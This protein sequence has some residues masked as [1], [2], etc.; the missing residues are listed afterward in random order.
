MWVRPY[1]LR[2]EE[3]GAYKNLMSELS[4]ENPEVNGT[5]W[6]WT[7]WSVTWPFHIG[8]MR[9]VSHISNVP[10]AGQ[11][12]AH[13]LRCTSGNLVVFALRFAYLHFALR[14]YNEDII[15]TIAFFLRLL[16]LS[17]R[18]LNMIN[19]FPTDGDRYRVKRCAQC[20]F[21]THRYGRESSKRLSYLCS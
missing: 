4:L 8:A 12:P 6:S 18:I 3:Q 2:R 16:T 19:N 1:L 15:A 9:T 7:E 10:V 17:Q 11:R 13:I 14:I 5:G 21:A 20:C